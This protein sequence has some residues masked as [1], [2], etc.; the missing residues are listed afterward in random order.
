MLTR[1]L[2]AL[3]L[4]GIDVSTTVDAGLRTRSD[5]AQLDY[6]RRTHR[7]IVTH[8]ADFLRLAATTNDHPGVVFGSRTSRTVGAMIRRLILIYEVLT[9]EE[10]SGRVEYLKHPRCA[11]SLAPL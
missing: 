9:S 5:T 8:D 6:V 7:V 10:M 3:H 4:H 2:R 11:P 1:I